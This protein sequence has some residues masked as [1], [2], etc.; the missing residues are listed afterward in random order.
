[1]NAQ[2][3]KKG[4]FLSEQVFCY[5]IIVSHYTAC[6]LLEKLR[7]CSESVSVDESFAISSGLLNLVIVLVNDVK[8]HR[9]ERETQRETSVGERFKKETASE[10]DRKVGG[11]NKKRERWPET[12]LRSCQTA[13]FIIT[14]TASFISSI[15]HRRTIATGTRQT[16]I[17]GR[18]MECQSI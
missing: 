1:M 7:V 14:C 15:K 4:N 6:I 3:E 11:G 17:N 9:L 8:Q 13:P 18:K 5:L 10:R 16:V 2:Y 12:E